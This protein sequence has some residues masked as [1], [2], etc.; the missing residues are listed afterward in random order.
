V[1]VFLC[2]SSVIDGISF[3]SHI[4]AV[5]VVPACHYGR[6]SGGWLVQ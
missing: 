6:T 5:V 2:R 4:V 3:S 1:A